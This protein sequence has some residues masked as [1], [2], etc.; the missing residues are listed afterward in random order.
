MCN[1]GMELFGYTKRITV[2]FVSCMI[3]SF[4]GSKRLFYANYAWNSARLALAELRGMT[5]KCHPFR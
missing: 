2:P 4:P 5:Y 1:S 3:D